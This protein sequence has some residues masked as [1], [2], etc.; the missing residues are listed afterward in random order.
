[1]SECAPISLAPTELFAKSTRCAF[2]GAMPFTTDLEARKPSRIGQVLTLDA[3]QVL[4]V[5]KRNPRARRYVLR[6]NQQGQAQVTV[7]RS[8]SAAEAFRFAHRNKSWLE[9]QFQR[10]ANLP[11]RPVEWSLGSKVLFRGELT[12][13]EPGFDG[14]VGSSSVRLGSEVIPVRNLQSDLRPALERHLWS[15][16]ARE[17]PPKVIEFATQHQLQV[18][19]VTV[20]NQKSRWGSCSRKSTISLNWRLVQAP[21]FVLDYIIL[22]ELMHL[23]HMNHSLRYWREVQ[24]VCPEYEVAER[25]LKKNACL[26]RV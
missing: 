14:A 1:V 8:G 5:I 11:K 7:P 21:P 20:R 19:R 6:L 17:L 18:R 13:I 9:R 24:R 4:L 2:T 25:W 12:P 22:H 10:L 23:R 15:L 3:R 16:A 26:L